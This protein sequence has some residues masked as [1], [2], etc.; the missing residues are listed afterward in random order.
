M[1]VSLV[2]WCPDK[3]VLSYQALYISYCLGFKLAVGPEMNSLHD[4]PLSPT[5]WEPRVLESFTDYTT[6]QVEK[7]LQYAQKRLTRKVSPITEDALTLYAEVATKLLQND[8]DYLKHSM[9][10]MDEVLDSRLVFRRDRE[11]SG[12]AAELRRLRELEF[13]SNYGDY[14][15]E[16]TKEL[17]IHA[18]TAKRSGY[19]NLSGKHRWTAIAERLKVQIQEGG[20]PR[21]CVRGAVTDACSTYGWDVVH[22]L[23]IFETYAGRNDSVHSDLQDHIQHRRWAKL[24]TL[25]HRDLRELPNVIPIHLSSD[26]SKWFRTLQQ[27]EEWYFTHLAGDEN[28]PDTWLPNGPKAV[29]AQEEKKAVDKIANEKAEKQKEIVLA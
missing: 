9:R 8:D 19:E 24:A 28:D 20:D 26:I 18:S 14:L 16:A 23:C 1:I 27:I 10:L 2:A 6:S 12:L 3:L 15:S 22:M 4:V 29:A 7:R 25:L 11:E 5:D 21:K 13:V 17:R